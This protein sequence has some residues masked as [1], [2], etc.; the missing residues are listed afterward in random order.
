MLIEQLICHYSFSF[1]LF[2]LFYDTKEFSQK[3]H[4]ANVNLIF[5]YL[6]LVNREEKGNDKKSLIR[7]VS[8]IVWLFLLFFFLSSC[9]VLRWNVFVPLFLH[10]CSS[11]D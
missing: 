6:Q 7:L 2:F 3:I 10:F 4:F 5:L 11:H 9:L 8:F 1:L